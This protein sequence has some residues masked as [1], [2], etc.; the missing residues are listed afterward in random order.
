MVRQKSLFQ[1]TSRK[2]GSEKKPLMQEIIRCIEVTSS[3]GSS[4]DIFRFRKEIFG[5]SRSTEGIVWNSYTTVKRKSETA[6]DTMD[7]LKIAQRKE[8]AFE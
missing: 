4:I 1:K 3:N 8:K 5:S 6:S 2:F 7:K